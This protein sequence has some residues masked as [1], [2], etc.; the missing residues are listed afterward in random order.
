MSM[1]VKTLPPPSHFK[2]NTYQCQLQ[3]RLP[4]P[5][6]EPPRRSRYS[7]DL[8]RPTSAL[9]VCLSHRSLLNHDRCAL[10]EPSR[11]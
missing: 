10:P 9:S 6:L 8:S 3:P 7:I 2:V 4:S 1:K 11:M 5:Y